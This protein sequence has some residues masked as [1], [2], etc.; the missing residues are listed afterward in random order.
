MR[1]VTAALAIALTAGPA[2]AAP[3]GAE[4]V[5][6][7]YRYGPITIAPY[8]VKQS[9]AT[10]GVPRPDVDAS[11][12]AMSVD[13]VD[14]EHRPI[15]IQRLMLHHIVFSNLGHHDA[16]CDRFTLLDSKTR[17]PALA[18][19]FFG[20]GEEGNRLVLPPG[21]GYPIK[22]KDPWLL[23]WMLMNHRNRVERGYIEYTVTYDMAPDITPVTPLWLDVRN[24]RADPIF[25]VPGGGRRGS[26]YRTTGTWTP[27]QSG[28]IIAGG[29]HVHGGGKSL[30]LSQPTCG[31]RR[32]GVAR[33]AWGLASHPFYHVR[34]ILHEPGP[35]SMSAFWTQKGIP[36]AAGEPLR[37]TANYDGQ[38][39]HTRVMGIMG[40]Y[41]APDQSAT[42]RCAPLPDDIQSFTTSLPHRTEVPVFTVPLTGLD[43]M[44]RAHTIARPPGPT[45]RMP[46]GG[47]VDVGDSFFGTR[48]IEVRRGARLRWRFD[49]SLLHNVTL[50]S[51][52]RGFASAH[53]NGGRTYSQRFTTPGT[54]RIF[55]GLHPVAMTETVTVR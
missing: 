45:A 20:R 52:P 15:P 53:L 33:P 4:P 5:T 13:I 43:S 50:A 40:L 19:R 36:V 47:T 21:Y 38:R 16:T 27:P 51:G 22:A 11:I 17:V 49:T 23:T 42:Q 34:P 25:N 39:P 44:G 1:I 9:D 32:L 54:Y 46:G 24:C 12:T 10:M 18:E 28:R 30:V 14:A 48:N 3:A 8:E 6:K 31:N 55:C 41:F 7:T 2:L 29:G 35:I 26:T 37:L